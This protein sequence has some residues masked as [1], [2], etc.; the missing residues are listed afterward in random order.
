[1]ALEEETMVSSLTLSYSETAKFWKVIVSQESK[2]MR[3]SVQWKLY[4]EK[5]DHSRSKKENVLPFCE[6][7]LTAQLFKSP[8]APGAA[9][10]FLTSL[11]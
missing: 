7:S 10:I 6:K 4:I 3:P 5:G 2:R 11:T 9:A 8:A 1:M